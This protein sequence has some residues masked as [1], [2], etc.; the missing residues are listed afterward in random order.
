MILVVI[1]LLLTL[2]EDIIFGISTTLSIVLWVSYLIPV[3]TL[4]QLLLVAPVWASDIHWTVKIF[5]S[6]LLLAALFISWLLYYW[7]LLGPYGW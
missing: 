1:G 5:H 4:G 6:L 7:N 3:L 2:G